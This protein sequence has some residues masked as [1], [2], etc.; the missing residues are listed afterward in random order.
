MREG[1]AEE[2]YQALIRRNLT[3]NYTAHLL[4]GLLGQTGF[5]LVNAPTF[6]PAYVLL[7]SGSEL[8]VGLAR[9]IQYLGMF[10]SP[11]LGAT[12]IEHRRR[13]LPIGFVVGGLMRLQVLGLA[14]AGFF[15]SPEWTVVAI[16]G[17]LGLFGFFMG[18]QG[19]I[20][21]YLMSKLIPVEL[22]GR[23]LGHSQHIGRV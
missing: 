5:R 3:R 22:R 19:V 23:L 12:L 18:M 8:V 15:L 4:H 1:Q 2:S 21:N 17:L 20:F 16:C 9:S 10:L 13:V 7:L 14:L 6:L 11:I